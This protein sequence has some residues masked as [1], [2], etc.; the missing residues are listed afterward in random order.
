MQYRRIMI[1]N[2]NEG[3]IFRDNINLS[4]WIKE[5]SPALAGTPV[6]LNDLVAEHHTKLHRELDEELRNPAAAED[7]NVAAAEATSDNVGHEPAEEK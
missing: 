1:R 3:E 6:A 7:D 2:P 5:Q 4:D